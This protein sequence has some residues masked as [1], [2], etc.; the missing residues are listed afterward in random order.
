MLANHRRCGHGPKPGARPREVERLCQATPDH[1]QGDAGLGLAI[2]KRRWLTNGD[3]IQ[4][5]SQQGQGSYFL[6][7]LPGLPLAS[8]DS[9]SSRPVQ[10][11]GQEVG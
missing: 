2:G 11:A 1:C 4:M 3:E 7:D 5:A 6:V 9:K 8:A 10:N